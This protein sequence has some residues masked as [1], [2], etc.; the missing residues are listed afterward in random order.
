LVRARL[1]TARAGDEQELRAAADG[2]AQ[3]TN[4]GQGHDDELWRQ[5]EHGADKEREESVRER[6]LRE[7]ERER[8]QALL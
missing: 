6:E 7:E 5:A 8:V 1:G 4:G 3:A 2:G